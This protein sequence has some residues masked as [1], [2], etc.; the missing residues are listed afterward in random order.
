MDCRLPD[1]FVHGI[2]QTRILECVTIFYSREASWPRNW[3][4]DSWISCTGRQILH[5]CATREAPETGLIKC[6]WESW[7]NSWWPT[8]PAR[9]PLKYLVLPT[10][11]HFLTEAPVLC[12][13]FRQSFLPFPFFG[14]TDFRPAPCLKLN[15][16]LL[17]LKRRART[18]LGAWNSAQLLQVNNMKSIT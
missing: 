5:H 9:S 8:C 14:Q 10:P 11:A 15:Y 16:P 3:T 7:T 6:S 1:F 18:Q 12:F 13:L 2:F 17:A 4:H